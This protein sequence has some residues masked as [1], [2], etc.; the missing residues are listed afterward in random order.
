MEKLGSHLPQKAGGRTQRC[1]SLSSPLHLPLPFWHDFLHQIHVSTC[2]GSVVAQHKP[3]FSMTS[4]LLLQTAPGGLTEQRGIGCSLLVQCCQHLWQLGCTA[5]E[6][7]KSR[8][9]ASTA[10]TL[11]RMA[12]PRPSCPSSAQRSS[13]TCSLAKA[14]HAHPAAAAAADRAQDEHVLRSKCSRFSC[15]I[16]L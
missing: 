1:Y 13:R 10:G 8:A 5:E 12:Q 7:E 9:A 11:G 3:S 4:W 6:P 2:S 14:S 15:K 16:H